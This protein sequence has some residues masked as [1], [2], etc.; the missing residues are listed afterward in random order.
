V[1]L[2]EMECPRETPAEV[3][4]LKMIRIE[5]RRDLWSDESIVFAIRMDHI[6]AIHL[7]PCNR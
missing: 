2:E 5:G 4:A 6:Q 3:H 7:R 1:A